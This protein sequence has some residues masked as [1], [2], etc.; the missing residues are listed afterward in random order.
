MP[1]AA[2]IF[3][4]QKGISAIQAHPAPRSDGGS[5]LSGHSWGVA[6]GELLASSELKFFGRGDAHVFG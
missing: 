3:P 6:D 2:S 4:G 5:G 1:V